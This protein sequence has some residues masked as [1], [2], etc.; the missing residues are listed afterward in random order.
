MNKFNLSIL[1][2]A[3]ILIPSMGNAISYNNITYIDVMN[4]TDN[5][6]VIKF[7]NTPVISLINVTNITNSL[8]IS[9]FL[10][11]NTFISINQNYSS[12]ISYG[13]YNV[14][15]LVNYTNTTNVTNTIVGGYNSTINI[16]YMDNFTYFDLSD[17]MI[18]SSE[19]HY[20]YLLNNFT[21]VSLQYYGNIS[22][23]NFT[24]IYSAKDNLIIS[25]SYLTL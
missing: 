11:N 24:G 20:V 17:V 9:Y 4:F 23:S 10:N 3:M 16:V 2:L 25:F 22:I 1:I 5:N 21:D 7:N 12:N 15:Y 6:T 18:V 14:S 19:K 13:L 8:N